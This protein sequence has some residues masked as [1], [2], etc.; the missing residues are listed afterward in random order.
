MD[1]I[2][3]ATL[4][5][6]KELKANNNR[7]W[8]NDN[9]PRYESAR[10]EFVEFVRALQSEIGKFDKAVL[11]LDPKKAVFRIYRDVRFSKNKDPYKTALAARLMPSAGQD[12]R[13]AGYYIHI[14][15]GNCILAGGAY[16]PEKEWLRSIRDEIDYD[17]EPLRKVLARKAFKK[18]FGALEGDQLKTAP[19]GFERDHRDIDLLRHKS[20]VAYHKM[21][22]KTV[23]T[24]GFHKYAGKVFK[25]VKPLNDFL[26]SAMEDQ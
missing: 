3:R 23:A 4:K 26:N 5:F 19:K 17:A 22:D 15:P 10:D 11:N 1:H 20:F 18:Y 24:A 2:S 12:G 6:L 16:G 14:Q 7:D 21:P 13:N 9:K 25:E 8:F